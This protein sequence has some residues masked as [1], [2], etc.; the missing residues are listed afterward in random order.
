MSPI[1]SCTR[2]DKPAGELAGR[3][4]AGSAGGLCGV[5]SAL[6]MYFGCE[7][8]VAHPANT[9]PPLRTI[10]TII[11]A[12]ILHLPRRG[13]QPAAVEQTRII[14]RLKACITIIIALRMAGLYGLPAR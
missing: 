10:G 2:A 12:S 13:L 11:L 9:R 1:A 14:R 6:E 3:G 4:R 7:A 5:G 8:V